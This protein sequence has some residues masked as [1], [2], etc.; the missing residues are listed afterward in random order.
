VL[1]LKE[2]WVDI[3]LF[4]GNGEDEITRVSGART[5]VLRTFLAG[6]T[7]DAE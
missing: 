2:E 6:R 5:A 3:G 4:A 1:R 7:T